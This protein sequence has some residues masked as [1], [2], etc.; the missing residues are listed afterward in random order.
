MTPIGHVT[1]TRMVQEDDDWDREHAVIHLDPTQ[2]GVDA[3]VG[4]SDFSHV[5][6]IF[7]FDQADL[8]R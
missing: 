6:V 3:L 2:L 4:L 5:E 7:F 1:S 8:L